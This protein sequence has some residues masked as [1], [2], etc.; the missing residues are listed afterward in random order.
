MSKKILVTGSEGYIGSIMMP[1][2][3]EAGFIPTGLDLNYYSEGNLNHKATNDYEFIK[4]DIRD[5]TLDDLKGKNYFAIVHLA[6]LSNDPLGM[7]DENLTYEINFHGSVNLAKLAK[8]AQIPRFVFASSCSLYGQGNQKALTETSPCNPQTPYGRSKILAEQEIAKLANENFSPT[9]MR[10]AT[11][12]G[13]SPRMRFDLVVNSL[14]AFAKVDKEI[15]ILGDGKPWRPLVHIRD[16]SAA[17]ITTLKAPQEKIHNQAFNVGD[18]S[19]NYQ[20]ISIAEN[21]QSKFSDCKIV[22]CQDNAGDTR[23]YNVSFEKINDVLRFKSLWSL[24]KGINELY[25]EYN[26]A[27][28]NKE[29]FEHR[30]YTRLKQLNFLMDNHIITKELRYSQQEVL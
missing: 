28:L 5:V 9:F 1:M 14:C 21:V 8:L 26:S 17:V 25:D 13:F 3:K 18:G 29:I 6:A 30:Y 2:L 19:E 11:A 20:I 16:I 15:K 23:D 4:K 27:Q 10:N 12:F 7:L 22:I 24:K